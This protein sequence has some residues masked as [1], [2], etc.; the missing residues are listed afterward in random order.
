MKIK[1]KAQAC[2]YSNYPQLNS[3]D[4]GKTLA[5]LSTAVIAWGVFPKAPKPIADLFDPAKNQYADLVRWAAL[6]ILLWQ[7]QANRDLGAA[8]LG[9]LL[10]FVLSQFFSPRAY[11]RR[12][13]RQTR[14]KLKRRSRQRYA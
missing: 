5:T 2:V 11:V 14:R 4:F 6:F 1:K 10:L 9:T 7:G 12:K 8:L 13:V 3:M